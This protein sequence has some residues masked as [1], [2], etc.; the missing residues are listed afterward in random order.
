M[1]EAGYSGKSL[2]DK[3]GIKHDA[4][5]CLVNAPANYDDLIDEWPVGAS[6][7]RDVLDEV[8]T[9]IHYF[10]TDRAQLVIDVPILAEHLD[11][12]GMLWVSWPKGTSGVKSD[13]N[14]NVLRELILPTGLVDVKVAA[15]DETWSG[16]KFVW[17]K[18]NRG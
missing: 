10:V 9:F 17:R 15:I 3:L 14:E 7:S 5:I 1:S 4:N 13:V 8:F 2:A 6:V 11:K 16:L 12:Q 18:S